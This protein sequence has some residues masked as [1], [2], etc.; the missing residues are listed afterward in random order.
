MRPPLVSPVV[1]VRRCVLP[2][3]DT[4]T[5]EV[6]FACVTA[7]VGTASTLSSWLYVMATDALAPAWNPVGEPSTVTTTGNV[8]TPELAVAIEPTLVTLPVVAGP[9]VVAAPALPPAFAPP[10]PPAPPALPKPPA[11][12]RN[13][14]PPPPTVAPAELDGVT[15]AD[16]PVARLPICVVSTFTLTTYAWLTTSICADDDDDDPLPLLPLPPLPLFDA[17]AFVRPDPVCD[18]ERLVLDAPE[19]PSTSPT[20]RF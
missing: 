20:V 4:S 15:T 6:P 9:V 16:C 19:L 1:T 12:N 17:F 2:F 8:A 11:K 3:V 14:P 7:A 18:P 13:A 10:P 5:L